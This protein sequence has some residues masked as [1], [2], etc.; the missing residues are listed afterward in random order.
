MHNK[1]LFAK[2]A[3]KAS[4]LGTPPISA[5]PCLLCRKRQTVAGAER[6]VGGIIGY[7]CKGGNVLNCTVNASVTGAKDNV[8]R[9]PDSTTA[10]L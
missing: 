4:H 8:G 3:S 6:Y 5:M 9:S 7:N 10:S 1:I 2:T